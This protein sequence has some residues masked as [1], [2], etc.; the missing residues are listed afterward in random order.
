MNQGLVFFHLHV[1]IMQA[2]LVDPSCAAVVLPL[3][4]WLWWVSNIFLV[5]FHV[6]S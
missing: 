4:Y 3:K 6:H 1:D 5:G 2:E